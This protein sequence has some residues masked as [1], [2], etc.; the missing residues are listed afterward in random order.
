[1]KKLFLLMTA[2]MVLFAS[3]EGP[4]GRDGID[5]AETY[6]FVE[7]YTINAN[8]WKLIN[9]EDQLNSYFQAEVQI[10]QLDSDIYR[11]GNVFCYM[12]QRNDGV[13]VQTLLPFTVPYGEPRGGNS[14]HIWIETYACDFKVGSVMFYVNFSDFYTNN[15]PPTTTFRVVLNY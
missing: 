15:R 12:Y 7:D 14:E 11:K 13:E 6:W 5:G 8:Q 9:G 4:A 10:P 3:C 1:M 2:A